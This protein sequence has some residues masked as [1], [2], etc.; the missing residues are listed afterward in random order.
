MGGG[1]GGNG[2]VISVA[3][4]GR[5][6]E[7]N[8]GDCSSGGCSVLNRDDRI[9]PAGADDGWRYGHSLGQ[10]FTRNFNRAVVVAA[11]GGHGDESGSPGRDIDGLIGGRQIKSGLIRSRGDAVGK[12]RSAAAMQVLDF[13]DIIS[14]SGK[15][16]I[17]QCVVFAGILGDR[18]LFAGRVQQTDVQVGWSSLA[19][20]NT[21]EEK[22]LPF[23]CL[24]DKV[25]NI[26][27]SF[28][29]PVDVGSQFDAGGLR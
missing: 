16:V 11:R 3:D 8:P 10:V 29:T 27:G 20:G 28:E 18:Q 17:D 1:G 25:I 12:F 14:I 15:S 6:D 21:G 9:G 24:E 13:Q 7:A 23:G 2:S 22:S 4:L 26:A 19:A 5:A